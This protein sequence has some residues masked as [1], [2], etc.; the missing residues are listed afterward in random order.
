VKVRRNRLL[1]AGAAVISVVI[2]AAWFPASAL[3][4]QH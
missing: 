4:H 1:M 3:Y 2:V